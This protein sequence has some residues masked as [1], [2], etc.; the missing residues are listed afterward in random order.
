MF[1]YIKAKSGNIK[2]FYTG[3]TISVNKTDA[4]QY[5]TKQLVRAA[6]KAL[7]GTDIKPLT[8]GRAL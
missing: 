3:S 7:K 1:Y 6:Y 8:I 2:G 5:A 4:H